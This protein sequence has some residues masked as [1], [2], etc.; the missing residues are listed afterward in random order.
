MRYKPSIASVMFSDGTKVTSASHKGAEIDFIENNGTI[1]I[2][3]M[4]SKKEGK[5]FAQEALSLLM[6]R[7][8]KRKFT[9]TVPLH[10]AAKHIFDKMGIEYPEGE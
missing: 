2:V 10:P 1:L 6:K 7:Y 8:K 3:T 5:G 4:E 9:A